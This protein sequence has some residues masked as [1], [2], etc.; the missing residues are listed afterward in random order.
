[1]FDGWTY[2]VFY[3]IVLSALQKNFGEI[4]KTG[5]IKADLDH[6][7]DVC[8]SLKPARVLRQ[9]FTLFKFN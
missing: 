2:K 6:T 5:L 3:N 7:L 4:L 8:E 1:M 9:E